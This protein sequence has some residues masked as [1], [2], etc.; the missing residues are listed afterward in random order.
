MIPLTQHATQYSGPDSFVHNTSKPVD[1]IGPLQ[2]LLKIEA[3]GICFSDTKLLHAFAEHPR[4][5]PVVRG[6]SPEVLEEI[7]SYHPGSEPT[8]PGH[9]P[10]ARIVAVGERVTHFEVGDRVLIQADW[11]H[12]PTQSSNS[13][14]GYNFEGG[15]QEYVVIDERMVVVGN[16]EFLLHVS[17]GPAAAAVALVEPWST[18]EGSYSRTERNQLTLGGRLLVVAD[19]GHAPTG[20]NELAEL[21][22]SAE[23]TVVGAGLGDVAEKTVAREIAD[24]DSRFDDIVYFGADSQTVERLSELLEVGGLLAIVLAGAKLD[25]SVRLDVG[26]VH[27][28]FVRYTGTTGAAAQHAYAHIPA[29][30]EI[31]AEE[32]LAIIGAA[33]PM[34]LMHTMRAVFLGMP[35]VSIDAADVNDDRLAHLH[36]VATPTADRKNVPLRIVNS[37]TNPLSPGYTYITCLVPSP[38]LLSPALDLAGQGAIV[39]AF[40][41][42]AAGTMAEVDLQ[43]IIERQVF[44][45][46]SSGSEMSDMVGMLSKLESGTLDTSIA[47]DA[48]TGMAG[49]A[50]AIAS[51][52]DRT[53]GGKIVVYPEL[54]DLPLIKPGALREALPHVAAHLDHGRWT[55]AAETALLEGGSQNQAG[56]RP[57]SVE[58]SL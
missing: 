7:P 26:R 33:G 22:H 12:L 4:K 31:R 54:H 5:L 1:P 47:L 3:C 21:A 58:R 53:S 52:I 15:L 46:G 18:V 16:E 40:A 45:I 28:D 2:M 42:F 19:P 39:N 56:T 38:S 13:A 51:V 17:E 50:D 24:L 27:Y 32:K 35:G 25:R 10:V 43:G 41:G 44:L 20:I 30:G 9:E 48:I 37:S 57:S 36:E 55:K 11:R 6:L 8:V 14:F 23:I 29:N 49:F 34:G